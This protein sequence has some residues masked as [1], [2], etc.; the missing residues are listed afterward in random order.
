MSETIYKVGL[1]KRTNEPI[2]NLITRFV[3]WKKR[4]EQANTEENVVLSINGL[5][6]IS[7]SIVFPNGDGSITV[8]VLDN[9]TI[10][11]DFGKANKYSNGWVSAEIIRGR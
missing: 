2:H 3:I 1:S 5:I 7:G 10:L 4:D 9:E 8:P 6:H 11:F